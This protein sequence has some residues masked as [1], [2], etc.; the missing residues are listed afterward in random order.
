MDATDG[1]EKTDVAENGLLITVTILPVR[2]HLLHFVNVHR[3]ILNHSNSFLRSK[4]D[5][6]LLT[7]KDP[8]PKP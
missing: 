2:M 7:N 1:T 3:Y 8:V 6:K 4:L 5:S